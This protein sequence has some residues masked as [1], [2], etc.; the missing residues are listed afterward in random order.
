[1]KL[2]LSEFWNN[3]QAQFFSDCNQFINMIYTLRKSVQT[4]SA[5]PCRRYMILTLSAS[6]CNL[7]TVF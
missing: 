3:I 4:M 1:M 2:T 7:K 5:S 6:I